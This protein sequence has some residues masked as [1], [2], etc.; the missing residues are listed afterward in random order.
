[1]WAYVDHILIIG[2][3]NNTLQ[4]YTFYFRLKSNITMKIG[5]MFVENL[6]NQRFGYL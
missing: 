1:M 3:R 2:H 4:S 5:I 6:R